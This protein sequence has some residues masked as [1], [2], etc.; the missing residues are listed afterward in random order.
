MEWWKRRSNGL[1]FQ[2]GTRNKF[3]GA[4]AEPRANYRG[5]LVEDPITGTLLPF[6]PRWK[7]LLKVYLTQYLCPMK[8]LIE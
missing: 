3:G 5:E 1:C 4:H 6:Y 2:W 7:T 8:G